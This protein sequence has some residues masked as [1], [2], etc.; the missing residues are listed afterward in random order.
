MV[1]ENSNCESGGTG[2]YG[3]MKES[4]L[5]QLVQTAIQKWIT[6]PSK[7]RPW[8][9]KVQGDSKGATRAAKDK[10]IT[11]SKHSALFP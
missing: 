5:V 6:A 4:D 7:A 9:A 3:Q 8:L 2:L 1:L 10:G 11:S